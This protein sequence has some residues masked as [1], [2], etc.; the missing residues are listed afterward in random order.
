MSTFRLSKNFSATLSTQDYEQLRAY[1]QT[2]NICV[3]EAIRSALGSYLRAP[4]TPAP[5]HP[6][7]THT[8]NFAIPSATLRKELYAYAQQFSIT[9]VVQAAIQHQTKPNTLT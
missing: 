2:N 3:S 9:Q 1:A 8:V 6:T 7:R 5:L 4:T